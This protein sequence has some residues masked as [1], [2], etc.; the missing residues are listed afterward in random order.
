[1]VFKSNNSNKISNSNKKLLLILLVFVV[2]ILS[3]SALN[4]SFSL[5][6]QKLD[7]KNKHLFVIGVLGENI[8]KKL[9]NIQSFF[10]QLTVSDSS[11]IR[12][13]IQLEID[14]EIIDTIS[15]LNA[16]DN[17]GIFEDKLNNLVIQNNNDLL[18]DST[19]LKA[20]GIDIRPKLSMIKEKVK[21]L[22][23][24]LNQIDSINFKTIEFAK[25]I[26][27]TRE[28]IKTT[29]PIFVRAIE[30]A[31]RIYYE[32]IQQKQN[33]EQETSQ[34]KQDYKIW[35][36]VI[37]S[38]ILM[39][40]FISFYIVGR[41]IS[42]NNYQLQ[43]RRD[44]VSDILK[45]QSNIIVVNEG[46]RI[47][48]ASGG[49]FD[50]FNKY[51]NIAE[52]TKDYNCISDTFVLEDGFLSKSKDNISW[53]EH[54]IKNPN[55]THKAKILYND[56][57]YIYQANC[58]K[59]KK[60][61][62]YIISMFDITKIEIIQQDLEVQKNAAIKAKNSKS[63]FLAN[64]SHE[65]RTPLNAILG[66][67]SLLK[68]KNLD[69]ESNEYLKTIDSSGQSLLAIVN[70]VLDFSKIENSKLVLDPIDFNTKNE[71]EILANLFQTQCSEKHINLQTSFDKNIPT[72]LNADIIRI[73]QVVTNLLSNAVKFTPDNKNIVFSI[74]FTNNNLEFSV[75]DSGIG[76][77]NEEQNY[78]FDKFSQAR[79]SITREYGGTGLGLAISSRLVE[80]MGG[81]IKLKSA[82]DKGSKFSFK[83]P[84]K[85]P[86]NNII[87]ENQI[88]NQTFVG[89]VLLVEDNLTNQMLM[90]VILKKHNIEFDL[91]NDG[92]EA[93]EMFKNG[94]YS[95]VLMDNNMPKMSG[96]DSCKYIREYEKTNNLK[97]TPI[98]ALTASTTID[99]RE[100][101]I[102]VG[103]DDYLSKP[104][105]IPKLIGVLSKYL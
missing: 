94:D 62:R 90:K 63:E 43:E 86:N 23:E 7:D 27:E 52:F 31:N 82:Q 75:K 77:N 51:K 92:V 71:F 85:S 74:V 66:F 101:F 37:T 68:E 56:K 44:Y 87:T 69:T 57:S 17:G 5:A 89:K 10:Y 3:Q 14:R 26:N 95:L 16:I 65:I 102:A 29:S 73:K 81:K 104:V 42:S 9:N 24:K 70:D 47:L 6:S 46:N 13:N 38:A 103:M 49:F 64:M 8:V 34:Q 28:F 59:S 50:L 91:A 45:S 76:M 39:L 83:I 21:I 105:E 96:V 25:T 32:F 12:K 40:G 30:K 48:D 61:D 98:V 41:Q 33:L 72:T 93:L 20:I 88:T 15:H 67:I 4:Y 22:V 78:I 60:Y 1:M 100:K 18:P 53:A 11:K 54:M 2:S 55:K 79:S 58:V 99:E 19:N 84:V 36:I 80:L 97:P 35:Q